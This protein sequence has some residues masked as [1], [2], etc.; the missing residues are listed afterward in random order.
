[1]T[2]CTEPPA[3]A[4]DRLRLPKSLEGHAAA[5][6][7][8]ARIAASAAPIGSPDA[9]SFPRGALLPDLVALLASAHVNRDLQQGLESAQQRLRSE[10]HG[11]ALADQRSGSARGDRISRLVLCSND[12]SAR[13]YR[14]VEQ[15]AR[16][17]SP[18]VL[19]VVLDVDA[20]QLGA[21]VL[22]G[23][24]MAR[25]LLV[26]HKEAVAAA[27]LILFPVPAA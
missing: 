20:L 13:F 18:R 10:R 16:D 17:H 26:Q 1:V 9:R 6:G 7:M 23:R 8:L 11:L 2:N 24:R 21:R 3:W 25:L 4:P 22:G 12:G 5:D 15:L 27:L 19:P 14:H